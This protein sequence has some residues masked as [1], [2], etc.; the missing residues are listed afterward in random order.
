MA[1]GG[2]SADGVKTN[3]AQTLLTLIFVFDA[4]KTSSI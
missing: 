4:D 2:A 1:F 3:E